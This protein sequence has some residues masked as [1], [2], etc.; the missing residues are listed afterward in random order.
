MTQWNSS[1][2]ASDSSQ[3]EEET[4]DSDSISMSRVQTS[5]LT[6]SASTTQ[7]IDK[8]Q[9]QKFDEKKGRPNN[10]NFSQT[11]RNR[12]TNSNTNMQDKNT[13]RFRS[14]ISRESMVTK[15]PGTPKDNLLKA[16]LMEQFENTS[17]LLNAIGQAGTITR[18]CRKSTDI[19]QMESNT[20]CFF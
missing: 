6:S 5:S 9:T 3:N 1:V 12:N 7:S 19:Y 15:N 10:L 13:G 20:G 8:F 14:K 18:S 16:Y 17:N 11:S 4:S 2:T